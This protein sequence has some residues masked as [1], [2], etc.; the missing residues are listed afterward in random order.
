MLQSM[1]SQRVRHDLATGLNCLCAKHCSKHFTGIKLLN[2]Y[3]PKV[4]NIFI[5]MIR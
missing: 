4:G 3:Y 5:L 2:T 1:V